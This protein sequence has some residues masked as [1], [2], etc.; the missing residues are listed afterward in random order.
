MRIQY[1]TTKPFKYLF[2]IGL[3]TVS[4]Y[5]I[6]N[7][8]AQLID[9]ET[10]IDNTP[11]TQLR[12]HIQDSLNR[13][14]VRAKMRELGV[15]PE[16]IQARVDSLTDAEAQALAKNIDALPAGGRVDNVTLLLII[17]III[18]LV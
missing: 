18:L 13:A 4:L 10:L 9:T 1:C 7:A 17:I 5:Y 14:E 16:K 3:F 12:N 8:Q 2:I 15:D 6:P 11:S